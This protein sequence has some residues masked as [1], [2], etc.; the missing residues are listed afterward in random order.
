MS[1]GKQLQEA[2]K[3]KKLTQKE[4]AEKIGVATGTIQQYE[5]DKRQPRMEVLKTLSG[6]LDTPVGKL[7]G[8]EDMGGGLWGKEAGDDAYIKLA[9]NIERHHGSLARLDTAFSKLNEKGQQIA[10]DR[11]EELTKIA[12]YCKS[13]E[14]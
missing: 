7:M 8:L 4:L 6:V 1:M 3:A 14:E 12:D 11:V 9:A 10:I 2:R 13:A 5:L